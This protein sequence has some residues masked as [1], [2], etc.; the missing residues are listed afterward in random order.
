M[1]VMLI[2]SFRK[3]VNIAQLLKDRAVEAQ[4][5]IGFF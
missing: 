5:G 4:V 1:G 3:T 2:I